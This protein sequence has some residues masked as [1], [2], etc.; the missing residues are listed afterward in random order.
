MQQIH[1]LIHKL[2]GTFLQSK[3][4]YTSTKRKPEKSEQKDIGTLSSSSR[5][6]SSIN[7]ESGSSSLDTFTTSTSDFFSGDPDLYSSPVLSSSSSD[8][9]NIFK[10]AYDI[11]SPTIAVSFK[12]LTARKAK[13]ILPKPFY[14]TRFTLKKNNVVS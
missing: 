11:S 5:S 10:G 2:F 14:H 4:V 1:D 7:S 12:P 13:E 6:V 9:D 3:T 8:D